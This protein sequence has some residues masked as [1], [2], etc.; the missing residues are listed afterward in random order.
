MRPKS[1]VVAA[2]AILVMGSMAGLIV[3]QA[4]A[5][6]TYQRNPRDQRYQRFPRYQ[7]G[8][9]NRSVISAGT[10]INVRLD[11]K[12]STENANPGD[13]WSGTVTQSVYSNSTDR[14]SSNGV[15]IPAGSPVTGVVANSAQGTHD[16]RPEIDLALQSISVNGRSYAVNA[17][18]DPIIAGTSR[19]KKVGAIAGGAA[20]GALLGHT[21]ARDHHGTLVGGLLGGLVGYGATRHAF[22]TLQLEPGTVMT[23][24]TRE[25]VLA[26]R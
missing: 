4:K 24:T 7:R 3:E 19:A 25:D 26:R 11:T 16:T 21:V 6:Q 10:S 15:A 14:Y 8:G 23:F 22:R 17:D 20:V 5:Q 9:W 12:I 2:A 1:I 13:T 18:T